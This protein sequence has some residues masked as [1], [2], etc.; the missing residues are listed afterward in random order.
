MCV[1]LL[2]RNTSKSYGVIQLDTQDRSK[3]F[4]QDDLKLLSA[5]ASQAAVALEN[6]RL[7]EEHRI[8]QRRQRDLELAHQIQAG[9]LPK[10]LPKMAGYEFFARSE[11]ALEVG[12][13]YYDFISLSPNRLAVMLGDL[14]GRG[15][16]TALLLGKISADARS[17]MLTHE[18]PAVAIGNL[19]TLLNQFAALSGR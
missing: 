6:A 2:A 8:V 12:G 9:F 5:V 4:T 1:P 19:N 16:T 7:R 15:V 10:G 3:K 14:A 18:D 11:P 13:D 17:C